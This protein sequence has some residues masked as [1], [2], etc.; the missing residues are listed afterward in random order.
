MEILLLEGNLCNF[1]AKFIISM[2]ISVFFFQK[3]PEMCK[4]KLYFCPALQMAYVNN[5]NNN[6]INNLVLYKRFS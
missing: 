4:N 3:M 6:N 2:D 5:N 1:E